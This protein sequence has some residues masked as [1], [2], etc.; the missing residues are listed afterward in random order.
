[1]FVLDLWDRLCNEISKNNIIRADEILSQNSNSKWISIKHDVETNVYKALQLAKIEHKHNIKA[2][3]YVQADLLDNNFKLLQEIQ[4]LGHEVTYH[5][6]VLDAN[7]GS[8]INAMKDFK[9]NLSK[10]LKN[11]DLLFA[12]SVLTEIL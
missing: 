12:Q 1:M 6:D 5:Y 7:N 3:Y 9:N 8:F 2:T 11:M 10:F 4:L